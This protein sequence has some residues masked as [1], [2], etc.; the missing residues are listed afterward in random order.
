LHAKD[1]PKLPIATQ[2]IRKALSS[3]A[4]GNMMSR[5]F[6]GMGFSNDKSTDSLCTSASRKMLNDAILFALSEYEN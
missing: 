6:G 1:L 2:A 4:A 5:S 3:A